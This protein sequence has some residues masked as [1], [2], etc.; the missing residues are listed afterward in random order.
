MQKYTYLRKTFTF[1]GRR[2]EVRGKSEE[3]VFDKF[4]ELLTNLRQGPFF[5]LNWKLI[6]YVSQLFVTVRKYPKELM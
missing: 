4:I 3:E 6:L 5:F 1:G 2:Y